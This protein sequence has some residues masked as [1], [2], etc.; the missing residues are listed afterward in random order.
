MKI[1]N[2]VAPQR[3]P[4]ALTFAA[5][6]VSGLPTAQAFEI[7]TGNPDLSLR[8]DNTLKY[9]SAWRLQDPSSK[10]TE[11]AVS[12]NQ[13]D[14]DRAFEKGL[15]S[16]RLDI[17]TELDLGYRDF[18]ARVSGAAWYDTE[19][20][21]DNDNDDSARANQRSVA[22]DEF[23]DDT[24]KLHGGDV[25]LLDAFVYWNGE[26]S[27]RALSLRLGRHG[28][29]W[30]ESL[31]FGANGIAG[32]MAPVD[33]VKAVSVP[34]TQFKEITR[35]VNQLSGTFQLTDDLSLGAYYQ[36]EW[37]ETRLPGAGSYFS[38]TDTIGEGTESLVIGA[39]P[40][41]TPLAFFHGKDKKARSSG[42]GGLQLR[43]TADTV[44]YG[45]YAIQYH[46]KSGKL[47]LKPTATG[48]DFSTG[49]FGEYYWVYPEDIR[50]LGASFA[51]TAGAYSFAGEASMRWNMPLVSNGQTVTPGLSAD[52][53]D[54]PLYAV[55]RSAHVNLNVLASLGPS[56]ISNEA[57]LVGEVAWNRLLSV[58][59]NRNALDPDATDDAIGLRMVYTPT[60]RQVFP[61]IDLSVPLG[62]SYF[63]MGKSA[64]VSSF[65]PNKGGDFNIGVSATYLDRVT[66]GLT[67]THYYGPEDTFLN[68][69]SQFNFEQALKDRDY[70]AFSVKTTF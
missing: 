48:P 18:G 31:F 52:N 37:E 22:Y 23:T 21:K 41:G 42:Q 44:E 67:Y 65:G 34:N 46:D 60:Y 50:A 33:V 66:F 54:D 70:L 59:K 69:A 29:I 9:S 32:G 39:L 19:Y 5:L 6:L 16:N 27:D 53:N 49:K 30:G 8:L 62:I 56:F 14:G 36:L 63:P 35:P 15:I 25:E 45:L 47:Y 68:S 4:F 13:D 1:R 3:V 26:L 10:L 17:L 55:G 11:G 2:S 51:T 24:R 12:R 64:V 61:G 43:Y 7:Q 28:L 38:T 40:G 58:T 20:Q 57:S